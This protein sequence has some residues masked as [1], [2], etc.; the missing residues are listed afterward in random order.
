MNAGI[1]TSRYVFRLDIT[2]VYQYAGCAYSLDQVHRLYS[3]AQMLCEID[4]G[5]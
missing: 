1:A 2:K 3:Q 5:L 4:S